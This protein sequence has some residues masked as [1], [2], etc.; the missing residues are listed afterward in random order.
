MLILT[1]FLVN[2]QESFKTDQKRYKRVRTAYA[3][4][5]DA[6]EKLFKENEV[7]IND[8]SIYL[9]SYKKEEALELWVKS[10]DDQTYRLLKTYEICSS[11]G[12][13]GPKRQEGDL[14]V[15]E[16]FYK[17]EIFNPFSNFYLS[18]GLNY[19]NRSDRILGVKSSLG[20]DIYIHGSCVTIGCIPITDEQIKELYVICVEAKR[21]GQKSIPVTMFPARLTKENYEQLV[22]EYANDEDKTGLWAD[23]KVAYDL[24][25]KNKKLPSVSFLA[26]GRH[27]VR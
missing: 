3:E 1:S 16:G 25:N 19:P 14:Q 17:I 7:N 2:A 5:Y 15:P 13:I 21:A 6:I 4:K 20:G 24:F 9:R 18:M 23:L 12:V 27:S 26:S 22:K 8:F 10:G 11:S